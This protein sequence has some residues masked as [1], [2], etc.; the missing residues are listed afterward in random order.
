MPN[1]TLELSGLMTNENADLFSPA[2]KE[3]LAK[4]VE[5]IMFRGYTFQGAFNVSDQ[6]VEAMY[7]WGYE[8]QK[9]RRYADARLLFEYLCYLNHYD[10]R[11]WIA[12]G[13]CHEQEKRY[14][15]ALQAYTMAGVL[16]ADSPI[17]PLRAAEC[18]LLMGE[19]AVAEK[20]AV[21][22]RQL[23]GDEP[24]FAPRRE[25]AEFL[26]KVVHKR[27]QKKAHS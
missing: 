6:Q 3:S 9:Q 23:A 17:P 25:R 14:Q 4:L 19:L 20:A 10:G 13:Y 1:N 15:K 5:M 8:L 21:M 2:E 16:D 18:L 26:V 27:L 7:A 12:L 22:A 11:F 24:K